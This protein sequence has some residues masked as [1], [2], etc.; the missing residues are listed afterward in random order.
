MDVD[1]SD[2]DFRPQEK[3]TGKKTDEQ[4]LGQIE[5]WV[6]NNKYVLFMKGSPQMPMCGYSKFV[7]EVL[8][9]YNVPPYKSV[10]V[11][12]DPEI[13]R[14][15]KQYSDWPTF[16]QLYVDGELIGGCDIVTEMHKNGT[17]KEALFK[18]KPQAKSA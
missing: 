3:S 4:I 7:V 18:E 11:L 13:R 2:K 14:L 6:K 17:L 8:K 1:G 9:F 15:V 12:K 5:D 10:D 16:P